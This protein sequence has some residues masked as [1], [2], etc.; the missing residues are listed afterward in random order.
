VAEWAES[1]RRHW[2]QSFERLDDYLADLQTTPTTKTKK[3][4]NRDRHRK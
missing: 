3:E 4:T 1:Y 2:E